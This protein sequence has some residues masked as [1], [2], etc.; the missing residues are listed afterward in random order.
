MYYEMGKTGI[1]GNEYE[2]HVLPGLETAV[3]GRLSIAELKL[4][5]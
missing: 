4:F 5:E 3:V 1:N 2:L